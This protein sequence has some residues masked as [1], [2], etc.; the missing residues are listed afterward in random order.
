MRKLIITRGHPGTGKSTEL[1]AMGLGHWTLSADAVRGLVAAPF[2]AADGRMIVNQQ[3]NI[4]VFAQLKAYAESR[5]ERG[6]T[7]AIDYTM[8]ERGDFGNWMKMARRHRYQVAVLDMSDVPLE[9]AMQRMAQRDEVT[10]VPDHRIAEMHRMIVENPI[11]DVSNVRYV[12]ASPDGAHRGK[13]TRWLEEP[14]HDLSHYER[15]VHIGDLQGCISVLTGPGG[16][17]EAG[18]RD[19]TA[20][21]FVGDLVDR[22]IENGEVMR[23][24]VDQALE[25]DNVVLLH[26]NH[27]T[28]LHRWSRG[29]EAVSNEFLHRT[30]PQLKRAGATPDDADRV[31]DKAREFLRYHYRGHEVFACHAGLCTLPAKPHL[32]SLEQY[33]NGTGNWSD[34]V[35]GQYAQNTDG[36]V[37][38]VH[39]HRNRLHA[40]V[41]A[42]AVSFNLEDQVEFGGMLR[43]CTLSGDG[44]TTSEHRNHVFR[45]LRERIALERTMTPNRVSQRQR[46]PH[47][48]LDGKE[49]TTVMEAGLLAAMK[50]HPGVNERTSERAPHVTSLNFTKKVFFDKSW[51]DVVVKARGLFIDTESAEIVARGYEKF[52]NVGEREETSLETLREKLVFPVTGYL[53]EN[54]FLGNIGYDRRRDALFVA[55]KSTPDGDFAGWFRDIVEETLP[56]DARERLRRYLRDTDSSMTFEVIDPVNDPHMIAYDRP[57]M[58]LLDIIHRGTDFE[59]ADYGVVAKVAADFGLP[60]KKQVMR[61]KDWKSFEGWYAKATSDVDYKIG[62]Q[63]AEGLVFVDADG[64]MDKIKLP[65]YAFWKSMRSQKDRIATCRRK[66]TPYQ[67][68]GMRIHDGQERDPRQEAMAE[69]FVVW[70]QEQ[71]DGMLARDIISLRTAFGRDFG[72]VNEPRPESEER[73]G[74]ALGA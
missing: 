67:F 58:I 64:R 28:H 41:R 59:K 11:E 56:P 30:L 70:C 7:L 19:D 32:V 14:T 50:A 29:A 10:R 1:A 53:K 13:I 49:R 21:V 39:G 48:I 2:I 65:Y 16:P 4:A 23:W 52:W 6:E 33:A 38:Q 69:A 42:N 8:S 17:L 9:V 71:D 27:E 44:W 62:G 46:L 43:T 18:L 22:G 73:S 40:P 34:D 51:D 15:I 66:G 74:L 45:P 26:G 61:L 68:N 54:G 47:W 20:Y 55:S 72:S 60:C 37:V 25:R 24:F 36:S 12:R 5:M 57:Q 3:Y 35:D 31:C 63:H